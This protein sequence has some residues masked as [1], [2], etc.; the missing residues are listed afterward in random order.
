MKLRTIV[1]IALLTFCFNSWGQD[2]L[3]LR[4][5]PFI[6]RD[7][8][9]KT[10]TDFPLYIIKVDSKTCQVPASGKVPNSRRVK[11][12]FEKFN[13]DSVQSIDV[14]KGKDAT[15]K[16]GTIGKD[17]VIIISLKDGTYDLLPKTL[18]RGCK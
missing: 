14:I 6:I 18:K 15:D 12:A 4:G 11:R 17:G 16:Y 1:T 2:S 5:Q 13:A 9:L 8:P 7:L 10:K 3:K